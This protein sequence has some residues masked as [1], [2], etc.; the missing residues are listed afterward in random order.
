MEHTVTRR[1]IDREDDGFSL[2]E[3]IVAMGI[4]MIFISLF[5]GAVVGLAR[6]TSRAQVTA[7]ATSSVIILFQNIDRQVRYAD[8]INFQGTSAGR[9]YIEFRTPAASSPSRVTT[10]TQ[11]RYDPTK[12]IIESRTWPDT[13]SSIASPWSVK[14]SVVAPSTVPGYPFA[15]VPAG[16]LGSTKQEFILTVKAGNESTGGT[17]HMSTSFFAKNTNT[18]S[19]GNAANA[20]GASVAPVCQR[21]GGTRP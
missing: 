8:G 15:M 1:R 16:H 17:T 3:L 4:F 20:S 7:E 21:T 6:G 12:A 10:C 13:P 11:W 14:V 5:L 18:G 2:I 9:T 19:P